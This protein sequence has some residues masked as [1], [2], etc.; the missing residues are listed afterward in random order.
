MA[1]QPIADHE[2]NRPNDPIV[3]AREQGRVTSVDEASSKPRRPR[4]SRP[5]QPRAPPD[6]L[7]RHD[8]LA[9][10]PL[11]MSTIDTLE[12]KGV[13]PRRFRLDPTNRVVWKRREVL[14][15]MEERARR[16]IYGP[17]AESNTTA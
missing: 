4:R 14:R 16:R 6:Y 7:T 12:K 13:F 1:E 11:C 9:M 5:Q 10:V 8:L 17:A 3:E 15:F 2:T